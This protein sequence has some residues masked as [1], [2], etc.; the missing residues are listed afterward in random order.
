MNSLL[1]ITEH[2]KTW[3]VQMTEMKT[4]GRISQ[5]LGKATS[6][7][8]ALLRQEIMRGAGKS[9][10]ALSAAAI[11]AYLVVF[12]ASIALLG[13]LATFMPLYWAALIMAGIWA[14]ISILAL[15][16]FRAQVRRFM[17]DRDEPRN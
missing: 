17:V 15:A 5:V 12:F 11:G 16:Y 1:I 4:G 8:V 6:D 7:I 9:L 14:F 13:F 3:S 2:N 10:G